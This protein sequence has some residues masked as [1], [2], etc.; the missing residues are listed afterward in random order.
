LEGNLSV[1]LIR[2]HFVLL[3]RMVLVLDMEFV[4]NFSHWENLSETVD[5]DVSLDTIT[6]MRLLLQHWIRYKM[7]VL[8]LSFCPPFRSIQ[9]SQ[10]GMQFLYKSLLTLVVFGYLISKFRV[11]VCLESSPLVPVEKKVTATSMTK[12]KSLHE[13]WVT[14]RNRPF[15]CPVDRRMEYWYILRGDWKRA[16]AM[17][18]TRH[19]LIFQLPVPK[20]EK[21]K[22]NEKWR[23]EKLYIVLHSFKPCFKQEWELKLKDTFNRSRREFRRITLQTWSLQFQLLGTCQFSTHELKC[24]I[25]FPSDYRLFLHYYNSTTSRARIL[26]WTNSEFWLNFQ[27]DWIFEDKVSNVNYF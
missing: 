8:I 24:S 3:C 1:W 10:I 22:A 27:L 23:L 15:S 5:I 20:L 16:T 19:I 7:Y 18:R 17:S 13:T 12:L 9:V 25:G 11:I 14:L 26:I 2:T 21:R 6:T 4:T